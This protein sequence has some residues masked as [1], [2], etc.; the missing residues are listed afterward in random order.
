MRMTEAE[1]RY[2]A[3][4]GTAQKV[5]TETQPDDGKVY[6]FICVAFASEVRDAFGQAQQKL[7][8][9]GYAIVNVEGDIVTLPPGNAAQESS[10]AIAMR[11]ARRDGAAV[12]L[13][14]HRGPEP[15]A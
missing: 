13:A 15:L 2:L 14:G 9:L 6:E 12:I 5:V 7:G 10:Q 4:R 8:S 3:F 1:K 11:E